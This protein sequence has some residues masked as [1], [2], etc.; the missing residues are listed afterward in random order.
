MFC[1]TGAPKLLVTFQRMSANTS[2]FNF[3]P[4]SFTF[5]VQAISLTLYL[6]SN[7]CQAPEVLITP[8]LGENA[9]KSGGTFPIYLKLDFWISSCLAI[10]QMQ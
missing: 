5:T 8:E 4:Q 9:I 2:E 6:S 3:P 7:L 1:A 10:M